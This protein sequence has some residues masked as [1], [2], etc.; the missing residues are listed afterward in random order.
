MSPKPIEIN[1]I[2]PEVWWN[3]KRSKWGRYISLSGVFLLT[4]VAVIMLG[5]A[6]RI[7]SVSYVTSRNTEQIQLSLDRMKEIQKQLSSFDLDRE[8]PRWKLAEKLLQEKTIPWSRLLYEIEVALPDGVR[9]RDIQKTRGV[10]QQVVLKFH[11]ESTTEEGKV[12]FIQQLGS[13][14]IFKELIL[15][16]ENQGSQGGWEFEMTLPVKNV[17]PPVAPPSPGS[18]DTF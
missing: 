11:G 14:P 18:K 7:F 13:S 12:K 6:A 5:M 9:L 16:R 15:E 1:F 10:D 3:P 8:T 17:I 4:L 2:T